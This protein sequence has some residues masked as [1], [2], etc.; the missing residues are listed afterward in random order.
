MGARGAARRIVA[1]ARSG[2]MGQL[3]F[4]LPHH[5]NV[6][7]QIKLIDPQTDTARIVKVASIIARNRIAFADPGADVPSTPLDRAVALHCT[8]PPAMLAQ[9]DGDDVRLDFRETCSCSRG[10]NW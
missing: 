9:G 6:G 5:L 2:G 8:L 4:Q 10:R 7:E 3:W 1:Y